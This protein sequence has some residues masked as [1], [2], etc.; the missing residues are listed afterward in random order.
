MPECIVELLEAVEIDHEHTHIASLTRRPPQ[1]AIEG[2]LHEA[3]VVEVGQWI[4]GRLLAHDSAKSEVRESEGELLAER[5]GHALAISELVRPSLLADL[6]VED[7]ER[8]A[9]GGERLTDRACSDRFLDVRAAEFLV[10]PDDMR[11]ASP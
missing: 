2:L 5:L 11:V 7:A 10:G 6:E 4:S 8:L 3:P 9:L 1:L